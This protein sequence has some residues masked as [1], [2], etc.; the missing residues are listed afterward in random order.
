MSF[1]GCFRRPSL[2]QNKLVVMVGDAMKVVLETP[3]FISDKRGKLFECI[4][5]LLPSPRLRRNQND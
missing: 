5:L 1:Q 3:F 2:N 4:D